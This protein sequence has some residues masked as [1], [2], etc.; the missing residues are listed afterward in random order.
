M[1]SQIHAK[2][3]KNQSMAQKRSRIGMTFPFVVETPRRGDATPYVVKR[4][5]KW[6]LSGGAER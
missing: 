2:S 6:P 4:Y 1:S 5:G 3:R